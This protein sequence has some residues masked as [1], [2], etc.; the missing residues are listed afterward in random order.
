MGGR[1]WR[2]LRAAALRCERRRSS[3]SGAGDGLMQQR[4]WTVLTPGA[5]CRLTANK[6]QA[7]QYQ[8]SLGRR[9]GDLRLFVIWGRLAWVRADV[10]MAALEAF[11]ALRGVQQQAALEKSL[12]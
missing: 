4:H 1:A 2:C 11:F 6:C 12:L 3:A 9:Q 8:R 10:L 5:T 7:F